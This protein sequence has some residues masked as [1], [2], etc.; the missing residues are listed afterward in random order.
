[1]KIAFLCPS[2]SR[3]SGGIF[4]IERRL[5][6]GLSQL[7]V[8]SLEVFGL[9]DEFTA[10]DL[11]S[12]SPLQPAHFAYKGPS[13]FRY[14]SQLQRAFMSADADLAH[15][16]ALWMYNSLV[17]SEWAQKRKRPYLITP[18]GMLD[19]WAVRNS[20]WK[21]RIAFQLYERKCLHN[22]ACIQVNSQAEVA[23]V[24]AFG[25]HNPICVIPNGID[26]PESPENT[27]EPSPWVEQVPA[28]NKVLLYLGRLHPKKGLANLL[29]AWGQVTA[30]H[31]WTLAIAGWDQLDHESELRK[32][33]AAYNP[34]R[35][36]F[37]GPQFGAAKSLCYRHCDAFVLPSF[38]EGLPMTVLE[39]WSYSKLVLMTSACNLPQGFAHR[40][41]I[42]IE[43]TVESIAQGLTT[44]VEM[45]DAERQAMGQ[46]GFNLVKSQFS[47][48]QIAA[49]MR[50]VYS[51]IL[52]SG[53]QP[54]CVVNPYSVAPSV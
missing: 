4:E 6:L 9:E 22:A 11:P 18:N 33:A 15:L 30:L 45:S 51:W 28:G 21:K 41:A 35:V 19:P 54:A 3:T 17:I 38:S 13:S 7:P 12:W 42:R 2:L 34:A 49:D 14:S 8:T 24:R 52:G 26:L 39:S 1:M 23:S 46:R 36:V 20:G 53:P 29:N 27:Q 40:A 47:W 37:L 50:S 25:L 31:G 32:L 10:A 43:P 48:P 44:L 5:A 16:H